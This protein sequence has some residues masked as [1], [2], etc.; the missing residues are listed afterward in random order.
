M[1]AQ[2]I[3]TAISAAILFV[4]CLLCSLAG[5]A[6][7]GELGLIPMDR[8]IYESYLKR[9]AFRKPLAVLPAHYDWRTSD[10]VTPARD[11]G[12]CGSCWAFS[13]TGAFESKILIDFGIEY[14]LAEQMLVSCYGPPKA[15]GCCG[16][17]LDAVRFYETA[18]PREESCYRYGDGCFADIHQDCPPTTDMAAHYA[19]PPV[20]YHVQEFYTLEKDNPDKI[21]QSL[22][23]DGP[24]LMAFFVYEDFKTYWKEPAGAS[25]WPDGAYSHESGENIGGHAVL[26]IGWDDATESYLCKNSWG[27]EAGPFGDGTFKI[28]YDQILSFANFT[29]AEGI[30]DYYTIALTRQKARF[31]TIRDCIEERGSSVE[32]TTRVVT[33]FPEYIAGGYIHTALAYSSRDSSTIYQPVT[34]GSSCRWDEKTGE[35]ILYIALEWEESTWVDLESWIID[36]QGIESEHQRLRLYRPGRRNQPHRQRA[37][38]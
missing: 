25:P 2:R 8:K 33:S 16:G 30:C 6:L 5:P 24:G 3:T 13:A 10:A 18:A 15:F 11:Q 26:A 36:A 1:T 17:E 12:K 21:K 32:L 22:L 14:D 23:E 20:C 19:C 31:A 27:A 29:I 4:V 35:L 34:N 38:P 7:A 28:R 9:E 37:L